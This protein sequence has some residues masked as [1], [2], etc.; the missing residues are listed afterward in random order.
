M[1]CRT[2]ASAAGDRD[3]RLIESWATHVRQ[4][5]ARGR[6]GGGFE[7][8]HYLGRGLRLR[9][10]GAV[11]LQVDGPEAGALATGTEAQAVSAPQRAVVLPMRVRSGSSC[12]HRGG[13]RGERSLRCRCLLS[14][15]QRQQA[16]TG[17]TACCHGGCTHATTRRGG[18]GETRLLQVQLLIHCCMYSI[19]AQN[20]AARSR[21][22]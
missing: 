13:R 9:A 1:P 19:A 18:P 4:G 22:L 15:A 21:Q 20:G 12:S 10:A 6:D 17:G 7:E 14:Q 2:R 5:S 16:C 11:D 8:V 3:C